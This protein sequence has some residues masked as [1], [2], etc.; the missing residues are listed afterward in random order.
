[1]SPRLRKTQ[2]TNLAL[3]TSA[4]I[5]RKSLCLS[6]LARAYPGPKRHCH[7]LKRLWR[8]LENLRLDWAVIRGSLIRLTYCID[9]TPGLLLPIL[10]DGTYFEPYEVLSA[11]FPRGGRAL[12]IAWHTYHRRLDG[13]DE[14]SYLLERET[15]FEPATACLE[16]RMPFVP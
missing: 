5:A 15:G 1:L 13:E 4:I 3:L 10:M 7:R 8:F 9:T 12:P 2:A 14:R 11:S 16:G 6:E